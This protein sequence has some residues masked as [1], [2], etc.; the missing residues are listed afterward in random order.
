MY[1]PYFFSSL[2][3]ANVAW[4]QFGQPNVNYNNGYYGPNL[5]QFFQQMPNP[6]AFSATGYD[7][8]YNPSNDHVH[9]KQF[10]T[11]MAGLGGLNAAASQYGKEQFAPDRWGVL[12]STGQGAL[13]GSAA[14]PIGA[15][16]GGLTGAL[17]SSIVQPLNINK[18]INNRNTSFNNTAYDGNGRPVYVGGGEIAQ[19]FKDINGLS[20]AI[21]WDSHNLFGF[22]RR[23]RKKQKQIEQNISRS[24]SDF[25]NAD[26]KFRNQMNAREDYLDRFNTN[27]RLYNIFRSQMS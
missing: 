21:D 5:D 7:N 8:E 11:A 16:A 14:G 6:N 18:T 20:K 12:K 27:A 15:L 2:L 17:T 24:Q 26:V 9:Q 4:Q 25:N 13:A 23:G 3:S 10:G 22:R 19:G 1:N